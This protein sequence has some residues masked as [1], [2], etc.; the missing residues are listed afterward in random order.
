M[1]SEGWWTVA[2]LAAVVALVLANG[3]FVAS[4]FALVAVR[5][6]RIDE[7]AQKG[8]L[9]AKAVQ[10]AVGNLDHFIAA[11]QL[12]ITLASLA[13]GWIGEPALGHLLERLFGQSP[14]GGLLAFVIAFGTITTLHIVVGELAPKSIALQYPE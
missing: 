1:V 2:Q 12:G 14:T 7:L 9:G 5:K 8:V 11:T 3:F 13:L 6:S 10:R 4:E